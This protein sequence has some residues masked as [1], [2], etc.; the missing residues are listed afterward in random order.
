MNLQTM[1]IAAAERGW[2]PDPVLRYGIRSMCGRR[3]REESWPDCEAERQA[4][5]AFIECAKAGPIALV[6]EKA[7]EQHYELPAE[8]FSHILG[9]HQKYSCC[10]WGQECSTLEAAERAA[11]AITCQRAELA[12]GQQILELGCGWGSLSLHMATRFPESRVTAVSNSA[13]QRQWIESQAERAG[14]AN[15]RV[16][17]AD[18]NDFGTDARFDR[19]VSVEMFEHMCNFETLMHRISGWLVPDGKLFVHIFSHRR[20]TYAFETEGADNWMGRY[21]FTGGIMPSDDLLLHFQRDLALLHHWRWSGGHYQKTANAWLANLD[22]RREEIIPI[23]SGV[24]GSDEALVWYHR[25]R[26]FFLA[27]AELFGFAGG[28][29]WGVSH[30]LFGGRAVRGWG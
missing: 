22:R 6:P 8:F 28:S 12:N 4:L 1:S 20:L 15:L 7:N 11:L 2:I 17:T 10:Y 27:C 29:E 3:L 30:Y 9:P 21:F 23:L 5:E 18:M 26:I 16:I 25:W 13:T 14:I 24:Y 19:V